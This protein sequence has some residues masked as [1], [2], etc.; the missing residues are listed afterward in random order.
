[1]MAWTMIVW[2]DS[3]ALKINKCKILIKFI[4]QTQIKSCTIKVLI[5]FV[6]Q[7]HVKKR[8]SISKL[9][10]EKRN[11]SETVMY[12]YYRMHSL[13]LRI[14]YAC[15]CTWNQCVTDR[16]TVWDVRVCVVCTEIPISQNVCI[17]Y[18]WFTTQFVRYIMYSFSMVLINV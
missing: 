2:G 8:C 10:Q 3:S 18:R 14:K 17:I 5:N 9:F 7:F 16:F 12:H 1:M 15:A 4:W 6:F 13:L 11:K